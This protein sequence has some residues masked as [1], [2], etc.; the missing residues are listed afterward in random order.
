[1]S[2]RTL[3]PF[4]IPGAAL[5]TSPVVE[6]DDQFD[7]VDTI[8]L[9]FDHDILAVGEDFSVELFDE[10][11]HRSPTSVPAPSDATTLVPFSPE[12][13]YVR[14][15]SIV[16]AS[17]W[18]FDGAPGVAV[19][20][21]YTF[22]RHL[23]TS[24]IPTLADRVTFVFNSDVYNDGSSWDNLVCS[25]DDGGLVIESGVVIGPRTHVLIAFNRAIVGTLHWEVTD[26]L[27]FVFNDRHIL[28]VPQSGTM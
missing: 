15:I 21:T 27:G 22:P 10:H 12:L 14:S 7:P 18:A 28:A 8:A 6:P 4:E 11:G 17:T 2:A 1:M 5:T 3:A 13:S 26:A 20:T 19:G 24:V 16:S 23:I 25:D 9:T